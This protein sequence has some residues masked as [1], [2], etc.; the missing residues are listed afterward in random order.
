[1]DFGTPETKLP[2]TVIVADNF[3]YMDTTKHWIVGEFATET[4]AI[5]A[6]KKVVD[7]FLG[8]A[9][10]PGLAAEDLYRCY[11]TFGEDP[12]VIGPVKGPAFSAWDYAKRR[13]VNIP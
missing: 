13:C 2:F 6:C 9:I 3:H 11:T 5:S 4:E 1:M 8:R 10:E 12:F 7:E